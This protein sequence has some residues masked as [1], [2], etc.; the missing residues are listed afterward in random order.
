MRKKQ[1][2]QL[3]IE[4]ICVVSVHFL[5]LIFLN[6]F[7]KKESA[8]ITYPN[9]PSKL[10]IVGGNSK[11][12]FIVNYI[13]RSNKVSIMKANKCLNEWRS[14]HRVVVCGEKFYVLGGQIDR[15]ELSSCEAI[16]ID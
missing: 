8:C 15:R 10:L 11:D 14:N 16:S 12:V 9:D 3:T 13:S 1:I 4:Q 6:S 7:I 5:F 2:S